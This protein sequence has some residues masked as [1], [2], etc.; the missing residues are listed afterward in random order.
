MQ[1]A[2][3]IK[4][5]RSKQ[6]RVRGDTDRCSFEYALVLKIFTITHY[7]NTHILNVSY[8]IRPLYFKQFVAAH[9]FHIKYYALCYFSILQG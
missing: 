9:F 1:C 6:Y 2:V 3:A 8:Y 5:I 4:W 7:I